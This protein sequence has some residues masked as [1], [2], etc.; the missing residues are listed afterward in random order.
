LTVWWLVGLA[1]LALAVAVSACGVRARRR[2]G[3]WRS[4]TLRTLSLLAMGA[5]FAMELAAHDHG[6]TAGAFVGG[7]LVATI[8]LALVPVLL[9]YSLGYWLDDVLVAGIAAFV[10]AIPMAFYM[11][12]VWLFA[13][14]AAGCPHMDGCLG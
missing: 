5:A 1:F 2:A 13:V 6:V 9:F 14:L 3:R 10:L 8:G 7:I 11:A 4:G 12:F